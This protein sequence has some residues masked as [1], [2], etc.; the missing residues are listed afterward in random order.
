MRSECRS[1]SGGSSS[2]QHLLLSPRKDD[3]R[4]A[5]GQVA[6]PGRIILGWVSRH[7]KDDIK[8]VSNRQKTLYRASHI[9]TAGVANVIRVINRETGQHM[10]TCRGR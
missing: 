4:V 2:W 8:G 1:V 7:Y 6:V 9:E 5:I 10:S 3:G